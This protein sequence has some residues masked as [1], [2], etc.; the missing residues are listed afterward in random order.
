MTT[1][2]RTQT[3]AGTRSQFATPTDTV[4]S[5][6]ARQAAKAKAHLKAKK[7]KAKA[8][9]AKAKAKAAKAKAKAKKAKAKAKKAKAK[10]I[11]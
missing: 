5:A 10:R 11:A 2:R 7:A 3:A 6:A 4:P 1:W 8:A 9:K